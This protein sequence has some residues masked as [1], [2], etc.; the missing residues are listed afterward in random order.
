MNDLTPGERD[1]VIVALKE[2]LDREMRYRMSPRLVPF[3]SALAKLDPDAF[4]SK[5]IPIVTRPIVTQPPSPKAPPHA[6]SGK[7]TWR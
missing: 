7:W 2:K 6:R 1:A 5:L 4:Q 3:R